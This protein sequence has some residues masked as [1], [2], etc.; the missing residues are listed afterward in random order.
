MSHLDLDKGQ[1]HM[2]PLNPLKVPAWTRACIYVFI[3]L[4]SCSPSLTE[5]EYL[6]TRHGSNQDSWATSS[7]EG[8]GAVW[9]C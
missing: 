2:L 9:L 6:G 7:N 4:V 8:D 5:S 3:P 1:S